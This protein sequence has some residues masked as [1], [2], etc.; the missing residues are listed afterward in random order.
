MWIKIVIF[1]YEF[2]RKTQQSVELLSIYLLM[3]II[4]NFDR[5]KKN[6]SNVCNFNIIEKKKRF[7]YLSISINTNWIIFTLYSKRIDLILIS[8]FR[9]VNH[10]LKLLI[11]IHN[12]LWRSLNYGMKKKRKCRLR[13]KK[14]YTFS[15]KKNRSW[16]NF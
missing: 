16:Y 6:L 12:L 5:H 14:T 10:L 15:I 1:Y 4:M 3:I 7:S 2:F 13:F 11:A 9:H 8:R